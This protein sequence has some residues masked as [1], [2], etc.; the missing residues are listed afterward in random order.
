MA[1][2]R[3]AQSQETVGKDPA[4]EKRVELVFDKLRQARRTPG[5]DFGE[6]RF[7]MFLHHAIQRRFLRPPPLVAD[8]VC[9][10]GAQRL[11]RGSTRFW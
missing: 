11:S 10:R 6:E 4:F 9:R 2:L 7:E 3:A 5:F 8:R 1:I